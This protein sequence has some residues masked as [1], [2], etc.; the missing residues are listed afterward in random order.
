MGLDAARVEHALGLALS[1]AGGTQ[2][3]GEGGGANKPVQVGLAA[4]NAVVALTL[5]QA[6]VPGSQGALEGRFGYFATFAEPGGDLE[7]INFDLEAPGEVLNVGM[8]PY[9]CCRYSH[10]TIDGVASLVREQGLQAAEIESIA[11]TLPP[12][13]FALVGASPESKR[14]P[15]GL[16]DAQ[17]SVYFAAAVAASGRPYSWDSYALLNAADV[18]RAMDRVN[19]APSESL[20]EMQTRLAVKANGRVWTLDVPLPK[21]E[22]ET[23]L[24]W[25]E[26]EAKFR[27][28]ASLTFDDARQDAIVE[29]VRRL[30]SVQS[31]RELTALLR[32]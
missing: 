26:I 4:H 30:E 21:G 24:S 6:G 13:G 3:F 14:R 11:V 28:L 10:G 32:T 5:A 16:V 7:S 19:A 9:P 27:S 17:F 23:P 31:M 12:A 18:Q 1:L 20:A 8:K 29:A 22:P 15:A 2:Q 25:D